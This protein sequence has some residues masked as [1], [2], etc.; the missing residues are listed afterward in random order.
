MSQHITEQ[1]RSAVDSVYRSDARRVF[2]TL[3]PLA[4]RFR[5]CRGST[6]RRFRFGA[7]AMV[8]GRRSRKSPGLARS[9]PAVSRRLTRS[10][11]G[12]ASTLHSE[13]LPSDCRTIPAA[14]PSNL[15]P[16]EDDRLRL[17][18]TCCHPALAADARVALTLREVCG[19]TTEEIARG[20]S[21]HAV[22]DR[23]ADRSREIKNTRRGIPLRSSGARGASPSV[24]KRSCKSFIS[25]STK[26]IQRLRA[27]RSFAP[28]FRKKPFAS[29]GL[30]LE[31]LPEPEVMGLLALM[32]LHESR[33]A[34]RTSP[35][36]DIIL[37]D[38][39]IARFG[40]ANRSMKVARWLEEQCRLAPSG[41]T[42][43]KPPSPPLM[44][45]PTAPTPRTGNKSCCFM[46][47]FCKS[48]RPLLSN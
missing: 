31:L 27:R 36:G 40:I 12:P 25:C 46:I 5:A 15:Q 24:L 16:I 7:P 39:Q 21:C 37:L 43:S 3:V 22:D 6:S 1:V 14:D 29:R 4:W 17:I 28:I 35:D 20:V 32:L 33:R 11:A 10:A 38:D 23:A 8:D 19:L 34:A 45:L 18:F 13:P 30:L 26:A 2:A 41:P 42:P 48:L 9:P 44:P 47:R